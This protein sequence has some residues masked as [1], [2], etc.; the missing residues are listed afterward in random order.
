MSLGGL[1]DG[2]LSKAA[3]ERDLTQ[4][5]VFRFSRTRANLSQRFDMATC[6]EIG[7]C[8]MGLRP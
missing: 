2:S 5:C 6:T 1:P 7:H 8:G 3:F 4:V